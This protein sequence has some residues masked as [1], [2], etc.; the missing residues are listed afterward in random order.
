[1]MGL[2]CACPLSCLL[3]R[4]FYQPS[5]LCARLIH[6]DA[7]CSGTYPWE[8]N[9]SATSISSQAMP[10]TDTAEQLITRLRTHTCELHRAT[11][12]LELLK[13]ERTR[14]LAY[15]ERQHA[16]IDAALQQVSQRTGALQ[17][18]G[19][20]PACTS[21]AARQPTTN[22]QRMQEVQYC[23]RLELLLGERLRQATVQL[24]A[25][26]QAFVDGT[27][28]DC[29]CDIYDDIYIDEEDTAM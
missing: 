10:G 2:H 15:L 27:W 28:E 26:R 29:S 6:A 21:F 25:A 20:A 3:S 11:E 4:V 19:P 18:G 12:E 22:A 23:K 8:S 17:R 13:A 7:I 14:C 16:A 1:M 9:A 24:Q 5:R